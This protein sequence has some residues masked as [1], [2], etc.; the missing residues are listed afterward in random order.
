MRS[1]RTQISIIVAATLAAMGC[2][3]DERDYAALDHDDTGML[4]GQADARMARESM[5]AEAD[6][7]GRNVRDREAG[8]VTPLDQSNSAQDVELTQKIRSS[9]TSD[10]AM[11]VQ[12]RNV[13]V[14]SRDGFVTLRGP[15]ETQQEKASIEALAKNAGATRVDNQLEIDRDADQA[16]AE[17]Y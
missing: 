6:N 11:S 10:G 7:T 4:S 8:A 15:V 12:A 1:R 13:K 2:A 3:D 16:P 9:I 5:P 17:E 14:I